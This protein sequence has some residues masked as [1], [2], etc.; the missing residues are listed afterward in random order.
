MDP[1]DLR[2]RLRGFIDVIE[3]A[4]L[5]TWTSLLKVHLGELE[6]YFDNNSR[7][8]TPYD[9]V[10]QED[11]KKFSPL[12]PEHAYIRCS[13]C[14]SK[15]KHKRSYELHFRMFHP[16][17]QF[18]ITCKDPAGTC[19]MK[20]Q[21]SKCGAKLPLRSIYGHLSKVHG[22]ERPSMFHNLIGF[23]L[24]KNPRPVF[25]LKGTDIEGGSKKKEDNG[26]VRP[27]MDDRK[28]KHK[29]TLL[30]PSETITNKTSDDENSQDETPL[31]TRLRMRKRDLSKNLGTLKNSTKNDRIQRSSDN[32]VFNLSTNVDI[33]EEGTSDSLTLDTNHSKQRKYNQSFFNLVPDVNIFQ[34]GSSESMTPKVNSGHQR[35]SNK[36]PFNLPPDVNT[37]QQGPSNS[38]TPDTYDGQQR[39]SKKLLLNLSRQSNISQ[40]GEHM[41]SNLAPDFIANEG[42][43][44]SDY[45]QS[46]ENI[47]LSKRAKKDG[48]HSKQMDELVYREQHEAEVQEDPCNESFEKFFLRDHYQD[49]FNDTFDNHFRLDSSYSIE[50]DSDYEIGDST[51]YTKK[52]KENKKIRQLKRNNPILKP[53]ELPQNSRFVH[54]MKRYMKTETIATVNQNNTTI[55]KTINNLFT[56]EDSFLHYML[57]QQPDFNLEKLRS[58]QSDNFTS[59]TYPID[60]LTNTCDNDGLKGQ[61]RLKSHCQLRKFID[62]EVEKIG[63]AEFLQRK[64]DVKNNSSSIAEQIA[65]NKLFRKY[66][67]LAT[68]AKNKKNRCELILDAS[69]THNEQNLVAKWKRSDE[70]RK[71]DMEMENIYKNA[72]ENNFIGPRKLTKYAEYAR[73]E[74]AFSDKNRP[75][76]YSFTVGDFISK[77]PCWYPEG[78]GG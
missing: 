1:P 37:I 6:N 16:S 41:I 10:P 57:E 3:T 54:D 78:R 36:L 35:R 11:F 31:S 19:R 46:V 42:K 4:K 67:T 39:R 28:N 49:P 14:H 50:E 13:D 76:L 15:F 51:V 71:L 22:I 66:E 69:K 47:P 59:L 61:E 65:R 56:Q 64:L 23:S 53:H 33:S 52:R 63:N 20:I 8:S 45:F 26:I 5:R 77:M 58:F 30:A 48:K 38:L 73:L 60:W 25:V 55:I 21:G 44:R 17:S 62:F 68:V 72:I 7:I 29:K 24:G 9:T 12:I 32:L 74:L 43:R 34:Q 75:G 40:Q 18:D 27:T 2:V 70:K